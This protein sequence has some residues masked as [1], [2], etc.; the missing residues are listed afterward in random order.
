V[1]TT[2]SNF[3]L[4]V[5]TAA[6]RGPHIFNAVNDSLRK[7]GTSVYYNGMSL[8]FATVPEDVLFHHG[9]R[10]NATPK[11]LRWLAYEIEHAEIFARSGRRSCGRKV[12]DTSRQAAGSFQNSHY[13]RY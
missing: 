11:M 6:L 10:R 9:N 3:R 8:Y 4:S 7:L 1:S 5:E 13:S 2:T 12:G